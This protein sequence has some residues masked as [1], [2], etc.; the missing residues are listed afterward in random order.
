MEAQMKRTDV[1]HSWEM[2]YVGID[3][4]QRTLFITVRARDQEL[5]SNGISGNNVH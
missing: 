4:H 3:L 1:D 2:V 5:F